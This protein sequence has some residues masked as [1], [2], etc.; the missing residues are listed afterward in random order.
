VSRVGPRP[1]LLVTDFA[2]DHLALSDMRIEHQEDYSDS[3]RVAGRI[4]ILE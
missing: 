1:Y 2:A 3:G 4:I